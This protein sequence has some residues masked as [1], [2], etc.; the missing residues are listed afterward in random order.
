MPS[1]AKLRENRFSLEQN[2][3]GKNTRVATYEIGDYAALMLSKSDNYQ[4]DLVTKYTEDSVALDGTDVAIDLPNKLP[5]KPLYP[6]DGGIAVA[7]YSNDSGTTWNRESI[8]GAN[9]YDADTNPNRVVLEGGHS[10]GAL[11]KV[12]HLIYS[13]ELEFVDIPAPVYGAG[14]LFLDDMPLPELNSKDPSKGPKYAGPLQKLPRNHKVVIKL[15]SDVQVSWDDDAI[16]AG[17]KLPINHYDESELT[18]SPKQL[19]NEIVNKLGYE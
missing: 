9:F 11:V 17:L 4:V 6:L 7:Y 2:Q 1:H 14:S 3:P 10:A 13:G 12:Y 8:T 15:N 19:H 5:D 16:N 18:K